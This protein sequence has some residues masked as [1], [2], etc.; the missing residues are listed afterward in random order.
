MSNNIGK[1]F[2]VSLFGE[3]HNDIIGVIISGIAPGIKL[4]L[5][6]I[7]NNL[8]RRRPKRSSETKRIEVDDFDI[9]SGYF[10]EYTTG[11]PL[12]VL[13]YNKDVKSFDYNMLKDVYRPSHADYPANVKY[14][15]YED[16]RGGGHFSG[17]L[18]APLVVA[19][20]I[21][22]QILSNQKIII[23]THIKSVL[24]LNDINF[25]ED[26]ILTQIN[27]IKSND[28]DVIDIKFEEKLLKL[29]DQTSKD[30]DSIGASL[31]SV[32]L[33]IEPGL[34]EP[35][36]DKLDSVI[37]YYLM[38]IPAIK[39]VSFGRGFNF[40][41]TLGSDVADE[42]YYDKK[43]KTLSNNNGGIVGGLST[44]M[45]IIVNSIVKPAS[46]INKQ[47]KT[48]K[49]ET[50]EE[51]TIKIAGRHDSSIFTR[52]PVIIDSLLALAV[53]D[54]YCVRYGYMW[55]RGGE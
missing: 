45:P 55:Q 1:V 7:K 17:R 3:S 15:G 31:E 5:D 41:K 35:F 38:S 16:F 11:A 32:I 54:A 18:T 25:N 51:V 4:D 52:M 40:S 26:E 28:L 14:L 22:A 53:L 39:G 43:I 29:I 36:F 6:L 47:L 13:M 48:V 10:N 33:N 42:Y 46:S 30:N 44:G 27:A 8:S 19:G 21:A 37:A 34:G 49:K 2:N 24:D 50:N 9:V 20:S 12:T 23:Q